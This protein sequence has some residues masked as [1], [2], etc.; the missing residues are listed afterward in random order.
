MAEVTYQFLCNPLGALG[1]K[2]EIGVGMDRQDVDQLGLEQGPD[3]D[4]FLVNLLNSIK[5]WK[6]IQFVS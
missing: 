2:F 4:P 3:V 5:R 1:Q 6:S